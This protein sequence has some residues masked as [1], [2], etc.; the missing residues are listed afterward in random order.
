[1]VKKKKKKTKRRVKR[2]THVPTQPSKREA[3]DQLLIKRRGIK[4][5]TVLVSGLAMPKARY[6]QY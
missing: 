3:L 2:F 6:I 1:M 4:T 5:G